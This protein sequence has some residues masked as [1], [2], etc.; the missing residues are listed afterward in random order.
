MYNKGLIFVLALA[1]GE[2]ETVPSNPAVQ[3]QPAAAPE[4]TPEPAAV[5][6]PPPD[7]LKGKVAADMCGRDDGGSLLFIEHKVDDLINGG[8]KKICCEGDNPVHTDGI[9]ELDWPSSDVP[10]CSMWDDYR[11]GIFARYGYIFKSPKWK[12][13]F[14]KMDWYEPRS[15]FDEAWLSET[16]KANVAVLKKYAAEKYICMDEG[17]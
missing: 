3:A 7:P 9:C 16:A 6:K 15:D 1:C 12:D 4:P 5:A 17:K 13:R 10:D 14:E 8:W 2:Q 11:N